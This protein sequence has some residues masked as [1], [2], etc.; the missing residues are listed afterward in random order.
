MSDTKEC[1]RCHETKPGSEFY[2]NALA[3]DGLSSWCKAC[4]SQYQV[5]RRAAKRAL[6]PKPEPEPLAGISKRCPR[7]EC[8]KDLTE[9]APAKTGK[10]RRDGW[11]RVCRNLYKMECMRRLRLA[12]GMWPT[13]RRQ[14]NAEHTRKWM[15][16]AEKAESGR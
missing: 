11:C 13:N 16:I 5:D 7:C 1:R 12:T 10:Y 9:F 2:Q 15:R 14:K 6:R 8:E 4:V 3:R